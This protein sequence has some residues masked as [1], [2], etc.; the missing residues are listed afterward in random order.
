VKIVS[1]IISSNI[2]PLCRF[3]R[4]KISITPV[5]KG[6]LKIYGCRLFLFNCI[7]EILVP[8]DIE[9]YKVEI[10]DRDKFNAKHELLNYRGIKYKAMRKLKTM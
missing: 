7:E 5:E 6:E 10:D 8:K 1:N 4:I 2:P 3:Y 9:S